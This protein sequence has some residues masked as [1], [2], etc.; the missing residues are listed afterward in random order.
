MREYGFSQARILRHKGRI[1]DSVLIRRKNTGLW[2][3]V[4]SHI[5]CSFSVLRFSWKKE[6]S[7]TKTGEKGLMTLGL[8]AN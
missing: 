2:K 6:I 4:F 5:L 3:P 7:L 1:Y 8:L